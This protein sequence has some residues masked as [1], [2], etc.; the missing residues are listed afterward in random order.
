MHAA[1]LQSR[2]SK[3]TKRKLTAK[4]HKG[5]NDNWELGD[6]MTDEFGDDKY[7]VADIGKDKFARP[8]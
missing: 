4:S 5:F 1:H 7:K 3:Q 2:Y 8:T 6:K